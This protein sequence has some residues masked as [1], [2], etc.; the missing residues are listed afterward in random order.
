MKISNRFRKQI[1]DRVSEAVM[2]IYDEHCPFH[3]EVG[4]EMWNE[5]QKKLWDI[6][7]ETESRICSKLNSFLCAQ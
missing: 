2:T 7:T 1:L 4:P 6:I 3:L 5:E